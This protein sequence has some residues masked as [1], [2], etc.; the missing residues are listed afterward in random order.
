MFVKLTLFR[1]KAIVMVNMDNVSD[2]SSTSGGTTVLMRVGLESLHVKES[3]GKIMDLMAMVEA[4]GQG[5]GD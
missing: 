3:P 5:F 4:E 2:F 1:D